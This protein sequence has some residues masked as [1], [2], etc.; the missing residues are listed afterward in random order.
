M[1]SPPLYRVDT[2]D[3][4]SHLSKVIQLLQGAASLGKLEDS[5]IEVQA[6][7]LWVLPTTGF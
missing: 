3:E 5:A 6:P 7:S 1:V 4:R 2:E